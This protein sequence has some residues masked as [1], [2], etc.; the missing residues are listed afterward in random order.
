MPTYHVDVGSKTYEVDAPDPNTAWAW[1]NQ[2]AASAPPPPESGTL[3]TIGAN[4]AGGLGSQLL[5]AGAAAAD[6]TG[7]S[8]AAKYLDEKRKAV[9]EFQQEHGGNTT[10]GRIS[11]GVGSLAPAL[12]MPE[13]GILEVIANAGLFA[14]PGFRDTY[15]AQVDSGASPTVAA[16]HALADAGLMMVGGRLVSAGGKALPK[17]LQAGDKFLPQVAQAAG[18]GAAFTAGNTA[19][20]KG[21]DVANN[22]DTEAPWLNPQAMAESAASFGILRGAHRMLNGKPAPAA[23]QPP[24]ETGTTAPATPAVSEAPVAPNYATLFEQRDTLQRGPKTPETDARIAELTKQLDAHFAAEAPAP[25]AEVT[26]T[27]EPTKRART[28]KVKAPEVATPETAAFVPETNEAISARLNKTTPEITDANTKLPEVQPADGAGGRERSVELPVQ[29]TDVARAEENAAISTGAP[30]EPSGQRLVPTEQPADAGVGLERAQQGALNEKAAGEKAAAPAAPAELKAPADEVATKVNTS[31]HADELSLLDDALHSYNTEA[32]TALAQRHAAYIAEMATDTSAPK[33]VR[34]HAQQMVDN[35]LDPKDI[36]AGQQQIG[37]PRVLYQS[38]RE[39]QPSMLRPGEVQTLTNRITAGWKKAPPIEV[40]ADE[41]TLP[42]KI[43]A[44]AAKDGMTGKVTGV[45]DPATKTVHL[46]EKNLKTAQDVESAIVHEI[47]G[48]H[49]LREILGGKYAKIMD[50]LYHGNAAVRKAADEKM[51]GPNPLDKRTAV[52][53]VLAELAETGPKAPQERGALRRIYDAVKGFFQDVFGHRDVSDDAVRQIVANARNHVIEG[54]AGGKGVAGEG[55]ALYQTPKGAAAE[56]VLKNMGR[57]IPKEEVRTTS[58]KID[59]ATASAKQFIGKDANG[60]GPV[61]RLTNSLM[62]ALDVS[63]PLKRLFAKYLREALPPSEANDMLVAVQ[64]ADVHHASNVAT[65]SLDTGGVT[66]D[67][68]VHKTKTLNSKYNRGE[69]YGVYKNLSKALGMDLMGTRYIASTALESKRTLALMD[70]RDRM[71]QEAANLKAQSDAAKAQ[72][73]TELAAKKAKAAASLQEKGESYKFQMTREAAEEGMKLYS[74]TPEIQQIDDIKQGMRK[75]TADFLKESGIW[76]PET[77]QWMLDNA[78]WI[79]FQREMDEHDTPERMDKV[80]RG[81]QVKAREPG[82]KGSVREVHDVMD[83]FEKWVQYSVS[84]GIKNRYATE[85]A[86]IAAKHLPLSE[87]KPV[88]HV[89]PRAANRTT[90]YLENGAPKYIEWRD[91]AVAMMFKGSPAAAQ[92]AFPFVNGFLDKFNQVFRSSVTNFPLFSAAQFS[93]DAYSAIISSGLSPKYAF[94]IPIKAVSEAVKTFKGTSAAHETLKAYGAVGVHDYNATLAQVNA[95]VNAGLKTLSG[96]EKYKSAMQRMN[97]VGDNSMRQAVYLAAKESGLSEAQAVEKAFELI[98]FHTRVGNAGLAASARHVVFLNSFYAATRTT[99]K[100]LSGEGISPTERATARNN[101]MANLAWIG[102]LSAINAMMNIGDED[103][104]KLSRQQQAS[105]LTLP[106]MHG[107]GV[108]LRPDAFLMVKLLAE[109]SVRQ[110]TKYADDPAKLRTVLRDAVFNNIVGGDIPVEQPEKLFAEME[111]NYDLFAE[112]PIVGKGLENVEGWQ[113]YSP[114]TSE[115]SKGVGAT[116][117]QLAKSLGSTYTG[118]SPLMLDHFIRGTLGSYGGAFL[119][120]TNGLVPGRPGKSLQDTVA[121]FPGMS[122]FGVR[123]FGSESI[124]DFY[125]LAEHVDEA[126]HTVDKMRNSGQFA[127]AAKYTEENRPK[128]RYE[129]YVKNIEDTLSIIRGQINRISES[130]LPADEKE[131]KIHDAREREQRMMR[132]QEEYLKKIRT[133][134][135]QRPNGL[136]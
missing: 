38:P 127:A 60:V 49:G 9:E 31:A 83:N 69:L 41:S 56:Q 101:L 88:L 121:T 96:W 114:E 79:P 81:L 65:H 93:M 75:W 122:R 133:E 89:D 102:G 120:L 131:R 128:L 55:A 130:N 64:G 20:N 43:I 6:Y 13:A 16:E 74:T 30:E 32:D 109:E 19:I 22:R 3:G 105:R 23:E 94:S 44:Q 51:Q 61:G 98:N 14:A 85:V 100:V 63:A 135:L 68:N 87:A 17:S 58:A 80:I 62:D 82:F 132:N 47:A 76:S 12:L 111:A 95:E 119:M 106:G 126:V 46:V 29:P 7:A 112:R 25:I 5:G 92:A 10:L 86:K 110:T 134:A 117:K 4:L 70:M 52:E 72:G 39:N 15:K 27:A 1:A 77:S 48:H 123:E 26:P 116:T 125:N 40:H 136:L 67:S 97:M 91:P 104:E 78:E 73:D 42:Q 124:N 45:Y 90:M 18:E 57:E 115:F 103:Y 8:N 99:L 28:P 129:S 24:A 54:G 107:W 37:K 35:E 66:Y 34:E 108:P 71:L 50:A 118:V 113:Q 36:A 53:E 11:A 59:E 84:N 33:A 21:I 2:T